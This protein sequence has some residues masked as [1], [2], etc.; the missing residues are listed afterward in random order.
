MF[1]QALQKTALFPQ[2]PAKVWQQDWVVHCKA[3]G[4]GHTALKYLAPYVFRVA[5]SN[6]RLV[7]MENDQVTFR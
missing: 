4:N 7:K 5:I 3:V 2:V 6:C 1:R